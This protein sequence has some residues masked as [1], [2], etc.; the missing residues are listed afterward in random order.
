MS[1]SVLATSLWWRD[2]S[3]RCARNSVMVAVPLLTAVVESGGVAD[4]QALALAV[5]VAVI[6]STVKGA[7]LAIADV[8]VTEG[9]NLG[10]QLIDRA[11]PA[12][13]GVLLGVW[14][15][16]LGGLAALDVRAALLASLAAALLAVCGYWITPPAQ[17]LALAPR[18]TM[19]WRDDS[20]SVSPDL[21]TVA[22]ISILA[23][24]GV[25]GVWTES[26]A[27]AASQDTRTVA[28]PSVRAWS[29]VT[30][31]GLLTVR[32]SEELALGG[33]QAVDLARVG[34]DAQHLH[35]GGTEAS[36]AWTFRKPAGPITVEIHHVGNG[37][38]EGGAWDPVPATAYRHQVESEAVVS[39]AGQ[40]TYDAARVVLTDP[41]VGKVA[42]SG[43]PIT[44][45]CPA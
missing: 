26:D 19:S 31:H 3:E 22:G 38:G 28:V 37:S 2:L 30:C 4:L 15:V 7:L 1:V 13:A 17:A 44:D 32:H 16:D 5:A 43:V 20:G 34:E 14:P 35:Q 12:A 25:L 45:R 42:S 23:F 21:A 10:W 39:L 8:R 29:A 18:R 27:A 40:P 41:A 36:W 9:T 11:A 24:L 33:S 6:V